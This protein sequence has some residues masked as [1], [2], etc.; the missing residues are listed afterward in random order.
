MSAPR[1]KAKLLALTGLVIAM[2]VATWYL[3]RP[4]PYVSQARVITQTAA[5]PDSASVA[6]SPAGAAGTAASKAPVAAP[7]AASAP[8]L[9]PDPAALAAADDHQSGKIARGLVEHGGSGLLVSAA[10]PGSVTEQLRLRPG[11]IVVTVNGEPVSSLE[12]FVRIYRTQGTP[13]QLT[14]LRNGRE[15]HL[16]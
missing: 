11:D 13:T 10:S 9:P 5:R 8:P 15:I 7:T 1:S 16:H 3:L 14:I 12:D 4:V 2:T 6:P